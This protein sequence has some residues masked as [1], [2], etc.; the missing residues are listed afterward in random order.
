LKSAPV[1]RPGHYDVAILGSGFG[2]AI[3]ARALCRQKKKV[4][5]I[6]RGRHP[7]FALGESSTPL[8]SLSLERLAARYR[9][10]D[11][12]YLAAHG[13]WMEHLPHLRRGLKRGFTFFAHKRG[14]PYENSAA[15]ENRMMVAASPNARVADSHWLRRDVDDHLVRRAVE[16]GVDYF[17]RTVVEDLEVTDRGVHLVAHAEESGLHHFS[18]DYVVDASG[19]GGALARKMEIGSRADRIPFST[20]LLF[21]HFEGLEPFTSGAP[22]ANLGDGP[23]PEEQAAVHHMLEGGWM[24]ILPFDHGVASAGFVLRREALPGSFEQI[25]LDPEKAMKKLLAEYPSLAAQFR[26]ARALVG[27]SFVPRIQ[28]RLV[29]AAGPRYFLLPHAYAF[30]DPLFSPG[31]AWTLLAVERLAT[32]LDGRYGDYR[33]YNQLLQQEA[34][35]IET[36]IEAA[37]LAMDDFQ[38]FKGVALLYF[39]AASFA[40][41]QQRLH[42]SSAAKPDAWQ[43]F[44]G[45][46]DPILRSLFF[47]ARDRL[48][49][50]KSP[51]APRGARD[52]VPWVLERIAPRDLCGFDRPQKPNLHP[53]DLNLLVERAHLLAM[54]PDE[55]FAALPRLRGAG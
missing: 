10:P 38:L 39:T 50:A 37:W 4:L 53:V 44:L 2:G 14:R 3:L 32:L 45:A 9:L 12:H 26:Q 28:H 31:I 36:L 20:S 6:E 49:S 42:Q 13:R 51:L 47:Q 34:D 41:T 29:R 24:Y 43:G 52:F 30:Y 48:K 40:E 27:P 35:Q 33:E 16:E 15:N 17:D 22:G 18:A 25:A 11:L 5:L 19:P 23:Y 21:G 7:R 46:G 54:E 8:A 1:D 55:V